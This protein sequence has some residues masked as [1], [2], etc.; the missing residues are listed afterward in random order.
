[1]WICWASC[2]WRCTP[3]LHKATVW[4]HSACLWKIRKTQKTSSSLNTPPSV[5]LFWSFHFNPSGRF[6]TYKTSKLLNWLC[7][8]LFCVFHLWCGLNEVISGHVTILSGFAAECFLL[9][10]RKK[11][12]DFTSSAW[13][14]SSHLGVIVLCN[15]VSASAGQRSTVSD[16]YHLI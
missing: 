4:H 14:Y 11:S 8:Y 10:K 6:H 13:V 12:Q 16:L 1:M 2:G 5:T 3:S 15:T 9:T 7:V